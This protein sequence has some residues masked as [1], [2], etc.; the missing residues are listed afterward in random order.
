MSY[1]SLQKYSACFFDWFLSFQTLDGDSIAIKL[2]L[3]VET[4][5]NF[6]MISSSTEPVLLLPPYRSNSIMTLRIGPRF[7]LGKPPLAI[8]FSSRPLTPAQNE[9]VSSVTHIPTLDIQYCD[10]SFSNDSQ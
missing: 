9:N 5:G 8:P 4:F 6:R 3:C 10:G 2:L 1:V 7:P